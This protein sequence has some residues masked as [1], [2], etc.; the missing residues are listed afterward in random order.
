MNGDTIT[1]LQKLT[2]LE[3]QQKER[4]SENKD[5]LK[6]LFNKHEVIANKL[7]T[8]PCDVHKE[9]M[10]NFKWHLVKVWAI[11]II[12]IGLVVKIVS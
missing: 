5:D 9:R 10:T 8:L 7:S 3:T 12:L 1:I 4:H 6:I 2:Q 11:I